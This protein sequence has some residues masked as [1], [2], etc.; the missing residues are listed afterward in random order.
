M[1]ILYV[2]FI[3]ISKAVSLACVLKVVVVQRFWGAVGDVFEKL[4][5]IVRARV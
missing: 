4:G 5:L 3:F 1:M 2:S